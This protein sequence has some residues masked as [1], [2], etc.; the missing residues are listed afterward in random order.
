M[1]LKTT[2]SPLAIRKTYGDL[3]DTRSKD[4]RVQIGL[5][6]LE[7]ACFNAEKEDY[8]MNSYSIEELGSY[9]HDVSQAFYEKFRISTKDAASS[10][11]D[12]GIAIQSTQPNESILLTNMHMAEMGYLSRRLLKKM[13]DNGKKHGVQKQHQTTSSYLNKKKASE[14]GYALDMNNWEAI[15]GRPR[16]RFANISKMVDHFM[17]NPFIREEVLKQK[18]MHLRIVID[19][20]KFDRNHSCVTG[21]ANVIN[22]ESACHNPTSA[23]HWAHVEGKENSD[24][25]KLFEQKLWEFKKLKSFQYKGETIACVVFQVY[26]AKFRFELAGSMNWNC[27]GFFR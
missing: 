11:E 1:R 10:F 3:I 26:D 24:M 12:T 7:Q 4:V 18:K 22:V 25:I 8:D 2:S 17:E 15:E 14:T 21:S 27:N 20:A 5:K 23:L 13:S 16:A 9:I 19:G 6:Y